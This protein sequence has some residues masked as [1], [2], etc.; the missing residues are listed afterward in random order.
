MK[1]ATDKEK[2]WVSTDKSTVNLLRFIV[3]HRWYINS[4]NLLY[5][6]LAVLVRV[7]ML[8]VWLSSLRVGLMLL[9]ELDHSL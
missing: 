8:G 6:P 2:N 1:T 3:L 4:F 9:P 7:D 5:R